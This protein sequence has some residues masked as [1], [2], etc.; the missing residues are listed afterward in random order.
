MLNL[1]EPSR[2]SGFVAE[3]LSYLSCRPKVEDLVNGPLHNFSQ[4]RVKASNGNYETSCFYESEMENPIL[5][6][7]THSQQAEPLN[8]KSEVVNHLNDSELFSQKVTFTGVSFEKFNECINFKLTDN[9]DAEIVTFGVTLKPKTLHARKKSQVLRSICNSYYLELDDI[10]DVEMNV[11]IH[12]HDEDILASNLKLLRAS[13]ALNELV[14]PTLDSSK[15]KCQFK[16]VTSYVKGRIDDLNSEVRAYTQ[17]PET[18]YSALAEN[19]FV[20]LYPYVEAPLPKAFEGMKPIN[21]KARCNENV[22][23]SPFHSYN[24]FNVSAMP[25]KNAG[26]KLRGALEQF[27]HQNTVDFSFRS[28]VYVPVQNYDHFKKKKVQVSVNEQFQYNMDPLPLIANWKGSDFNE[29]DFIY[30]YVSALIELALHECKGVTEELLKTHLRQMNPAM[31][32]EKYIRN[33]EVHSTKELINVMSNSKDEHQEMLAEHLRKCLPELDQLFD[34]SKPS[35]YTLKNPVISACDFKGLNTEFLITIG[36]QILACQSQISGMH[37][38]LKPLVI[39]I[40]TTEKNKCNKAFSN[41][42][43]LNRMLAISTIYVHS[44][45]DDE[46]NLVTNRSMEGASHHVLKEVDR[47][48]IFLEI[49]TFLDSRAPMMPGLAA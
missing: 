14:E 37:K 42:L 31:L 10:Y 27:I 34:E 17:S 24:N 6:G 44:Q 28:I 2:F 33:Q 23:W 36:L 3:T 41:M 40:E 20:P 5:W 45:F 32:V 12:N 16:R 21:F 26:G 22:E 46:G 9:I 15:L 38:A 7:L 18:K 11:T 39:L 35:I 43:R 49:G 19:W 48:G 1:I 29:H 8:K 47:K 13:A 25:S 4:V 30:A